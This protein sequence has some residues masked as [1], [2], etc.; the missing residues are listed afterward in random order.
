[1][2]N[3]FCISGAHLQ[4]TCHIPLSTKLVRMLY[5]RSEYPSVQI[6]QRKTWQLPNRWCSPSTFYHGSPAPM[7]LAVVKVINTPLQARFS[8][9]RTQGRPPVVGCITNLL[10]SWQLQKY[11]SWKLV[12]AISHHTEDD[13]GVTHQ[14]QSGDWIRSHPSTNWFYQVGKAFPYGLSQQE[15]TAGYQ[16]VPLVVSGPLLTMINRGIGHCFT[17]GM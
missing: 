8:T 6:A 15:K 1:M 10:S 13:T 16:V 7:I 12:L 11:P 14:C 3:Y 5:Q 9:Y 4:T 2:W 17:G